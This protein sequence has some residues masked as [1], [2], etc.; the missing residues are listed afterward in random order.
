MH[1]QRL[2]YAALALAPFLMAD[3]FGPG[4]CD[5]A[6]PVTCPAEASDGFSARLVH[7]TTGP[8][9]APL[10]IGAEVAEGDVVEVYTRDGVAYVDLGVVVGNRSDRT[11]MSMGI[12]KPGND[13]IGGAQHLQYVKSAEECGGDDQFA[14]SVNE[15]GTPFYSDAGEL[16]GLQVQ[17]GVAV[18]DD[19]GHRV[20]IVHNYTLHVRGELGACP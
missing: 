6:S 2:K 4:G 7:T 14:R 5:G 9:D 3:S 19:H 13:T 20:E 11:F 8:C 10:A 16:D 18:N 15:E 1:M 12:H 17:L